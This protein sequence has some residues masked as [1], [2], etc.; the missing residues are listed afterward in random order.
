LADGGETVTIA[1]GGRDYAQAPFKYQ[2]RC[3]MDLRALYAALSSDARAS[4][5]AVLADPAASQALS[6]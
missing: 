3:L 6:G 5:D 2:A 1:W 4:V